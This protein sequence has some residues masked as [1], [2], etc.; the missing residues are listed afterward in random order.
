MM[1]Q[2]AG[3]LVPVKGGFSIAA[4]PAWSFWARPEAIGSSQ[5]EIDAMHRNKVHS[6]RIAQLEAARDAARQA[7]ADMEAQGRPS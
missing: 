5:A 6:D 2:I 1:A 4:L 3:D 7:L